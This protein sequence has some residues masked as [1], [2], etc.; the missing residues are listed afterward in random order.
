MYMVYSIYTLKKE[1]K[2]TRKKMF[3]FL[4]SGGIRTHDLHVTAGV[5]QITAK[6]FQFATATCYL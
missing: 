1:R 3:G 4:G 6:S 2:K 5:G